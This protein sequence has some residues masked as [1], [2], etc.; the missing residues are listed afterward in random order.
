MAARNAFLRCGSTIQDVAQSKSLPLSLGA[1]RVGD[2]T[3]NL[4]L[5]ILKLLKTTSGGSRAR[6]GEVQD[7][8]E[9]FK[10]HLTLYSSSVD[11]QEPCAGPRCQ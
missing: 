5:K 9:R 7:W 6:K 8:E 1:F 3:L 4:I 10:F 2:Y 11:G